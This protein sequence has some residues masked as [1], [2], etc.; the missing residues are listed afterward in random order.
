MIKITIEISKIEKR[1]TEKNQWNKKCFFEKIN[2]MDKYLT[3]L[4]KKMKE[5][6][7]WQNHKL[8]RGHHYQPYGN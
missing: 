6:S 7:N 8:K 2:K 1:I 3:R 4:T 5:D